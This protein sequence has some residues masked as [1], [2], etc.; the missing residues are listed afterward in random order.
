MKIIFLEAVQNFGGARKSTLELAKRLQNGGNEVCVIDFWGSCTPFLKEAEKTEIQ[1]HIIDK[2]DTPIVLSN[3]NKIIVL[4]NYV[5]YFLKWLA[6][7]KQVSKL[8]QEIEVDLI[9]VNNL[10]TLS[11]L[12]KTSKYQIAYFAR[13][14][15]LP[16]TVSRINKIIIKKLASIY[17]GVSQATR[18]AIFA[19][20]FA[21]LEDI[22]VVPNAID[23]NKTQLLLNNDNAYTRWDKEYGNRPFTLLHCGGFLESKGQHVLIEIA[24]KL[25]ESNIEFKI[26]LVGIIYKGSAS[27]KYY[28]K[29][30]EDINKLE[31]EQYFDIILNQSDVVQYFTECDVLIHPSATEGLPRVAM[32]AMCLGKPV[33]GNAVGGMTDFILNGYTGFLPNYNNVG[34]YV[35]YILLLYTN[36]DLYRTISANS[37]R[38]IRAYYKEDTQY[39]S[40]M[41]IQKQ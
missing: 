10:K 27:K 3:P 39:K 8:I 6:Y 22:Y 18:H 11:L 7:R 34:D 41:K 21:K 26:K 31:L 33:I 35:E 29:I 2:R 30:I 40:F 24:K 28:D 25:K 16:Q 13:G 38:V 37:K 14:W 12:K 4:K 32:E 23:F 15:F 20:G 19:G 36:K 17:I 1:V 9:V 5:S